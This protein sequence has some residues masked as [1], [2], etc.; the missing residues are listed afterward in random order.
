MRP[1]SASVALFIFFIGMVMSCSK[2]TSRDLVIEKF[3]C[4]SLEGVIHDVGISIDARVKR[5]GRG[6]L[7]INISEPMVVRLFETGDIDI[8]DA[9]LIYQARLRTEDVQ[10]RVY[11]EM[12]CQ[13][14][15]KGEFFSQGLD[16]PL[17]GTTKWTQ[18]EIP[19]FL[20]AGEN[21]DNAKLNIVCEGAGTVWVDDIRLIK[22]TE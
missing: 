9:V 17:S 11:L 18:V 12:W 6:A 19:F 22:R 10:G 8:E 4:D 16:T 1:R 13:F 7:R 14:E 5:E 2:P 15:G 20:K 3:S 21:P